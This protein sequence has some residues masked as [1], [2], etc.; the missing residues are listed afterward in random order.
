MYSKEFNIYPHNRDELAIIFI[1]KAVMSLCRR[2][3]SVS[4]DILRNYLIKNLMLA[5][6]SSDRDLENLIRNAVK[7]ID[8][9]FHREIKDVPP[10]N[11]SCD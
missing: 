6:N 8:N 10:L 9:N 1:G 7:I 4:Y 11:V 3:D 2:G 5:Q